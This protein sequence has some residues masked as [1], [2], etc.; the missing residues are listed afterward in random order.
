MSVPA[1]V[2][3]TDNTLIAIAESLPDDDAAL[4]AIPGIAPASSS[5]TRDVL[6]LVRER[7]KS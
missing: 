1:Y 3:F 7:Q 5:S 4:V 2:V 6:G